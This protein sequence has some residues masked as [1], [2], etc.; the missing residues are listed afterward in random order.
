MVRNLNFVII[1]FGFTGFLSLA[2]ILFVFSLSF[3][4]LGPSLFSLTGLSWS[5]ILV[6][7]AVDDI[8]FQSKW[9]SRWPGLFQFII[10][11]HQIWF[12]TFFRPDSSVSTEPGSS[13]ILLALKKTLLYSIR[14]QKH[15]RCILVKGLSL[16]KL[17]ITNWTCSHF[18]NM[19]TSQ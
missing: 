7:D 14:R 8:G 19:N 3:F 11:W 1:I 5:V 6:F 4:F 13:K 16:L 17:S 18:E 15:G 9:S 10:A 12:L 2:N